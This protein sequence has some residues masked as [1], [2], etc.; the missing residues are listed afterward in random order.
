M[1]CVECGAE[2]RFTDE[3]I[4]EEYKGENITVTGVQHYACDACGYAEIPADSVNDFGRALADEYA[5]RMGLLSP[6]E[7]LALRK[8]LG[9]SQKKFEALLGVSSP[10]VSRWEN[11]VVQQSKPLD[12]LMRTIRDVPE[13]RRYLLER[14]ETD[15][16]SERYVSTI[17]TTASIK[18]DES[19]VLL[20]LLYSPAEKSSETNFSS[21][22]AV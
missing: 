10:A 8:S 19:A 13:A 22:L 15:Y 4:T 1:R 2:L 17:E 7:I 14:T 9:L 5:R 3:P 6:S 18:D 21:Q 11:G 12:N 16:K 20:T